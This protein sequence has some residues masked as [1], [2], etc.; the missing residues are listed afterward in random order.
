MSEKTASRLTARQREVIR[1]VRSGLT[2][3]E[4][5]AELGITEDGVKAHLSRLYLRYDV[6][7]R[8]AL[9]RR[10]DDESPV[11]DL[12]GRTL[13][14]LRT[15]GGTT[16]D[17]TRR[18]ARGGGENDRLAAVRE[19]L[20]ALD[21]SLDLV[22][23]LPPETSGPVLDALR[24]RIAKAKAALDAFGGEGGRPGTLGRGA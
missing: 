22:R 20:T 7:N 17:R 23:D 5:A 14:E 15:I 10:I 19:A 24:K 13:G 3:K 4:I 16:R 21:V 18:L 9:L 8:V 6:T 11:V 12:G 1:H 2:N